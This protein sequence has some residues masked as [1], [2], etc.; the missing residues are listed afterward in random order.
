MH[1]PNITAHF[2]TCLLH[3]RKTAICSGTL[4][5]KGGSCVNKA[6][7]PLNPGMMPTCG[8]HRDQLRQS[9]WCRASLPCGF[10]CGQMCEWKPH[11][12]QLCSE[13]YEHPMTCHLLKIP[14]EMRL[15]IYGFLLPN[16]PI[17][18]RYRNSRYLTSDNEPVYTALLR[19]NHQIHDEA[20]RLLYA[21]R[22][23]TIELAAD[24]FFMCNSPKMSAHNSSHALQD[25]QMQ[26]M[27]LEQQNKK[28]LMMARQE[29]GNIINNGSSSSSYHPPINFNVPVNGSS[30]VPYTSGPAEPAWYPPLSVNYFNMIQSFLVEIVFSSQSNP[31]SSSGRGTTAAV[32]EALE[33]RLYDYC[34]RLHELV[35]RFRLIPRPLAQLKIVIKL[36]KTER[37]EAISA[38]Q[39]LLRPFQRLRNVRKPEFPLILIND[40]QDCEVELLNHQNYTSSILDQ[41]LYD[42]LKCWVSDLSSS[43]PPLRPQVFEAYWQ[44]ERLLSGIKSHHSDVKFAQFTNL[45]HTARVSREADDLPS[46]R[47]VWDLVMKIWFDY[48]NDQRRFR[49]NVSLSIDAINSTIKENF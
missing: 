4:K 32:A 15:R 35:G 47:A 7:G 16:H 36:G 1:P 27:L 25:Y 46:F 5:K 28:R 18:A 44:L 40:L 2:Q 6:L 13:H 30:I 39:V 34:D 26:L 37:E 38:A 22:T 43:G 11:G 19:I 24:G 41:N 12:F 49:S 3:G 21:V 17:P 31:N 42:Y 48:V 8:I 9:A 45:L 23:F 20:V 10:E 33:S 14:I 29:Q